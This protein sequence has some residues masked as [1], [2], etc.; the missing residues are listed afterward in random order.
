MTFFQLRR[1]PPKKVW[2]GLHYSIV[3]CHSNARNVVFDYSNQKNCIMVGLNVTTSNTIINGNPLNSSIDNENPKQNAGQC[4][5]TELHPK[6]MVENWTFCISIHRN[7]SPENT[8]MHVFFYS[9]S[10]EYT[11]TSSKQRFGQGNLH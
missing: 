2:I 4:Q 3:S 1:N 5:W 10:D 6:K 7:V 8:L 9:S 11:N